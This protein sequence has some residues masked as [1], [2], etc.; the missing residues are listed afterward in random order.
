MS[1]PAGRRLAIASLPCRLFVGRLEQSSDPLESATNPGA[2]DSSPHDRS[3]L[4]RGA[5]EM[6]KSQVHKGLRLTVGLV[7]AVII[8]ASAA[9]VSIS[10]QAAATGKANA[11]TSAAASARAKFRT[12]WGHPDLQGVWSNATT[13]PLER[14]TNI[15]EKDALS[16]E[17]TSDVD[18]KTAVNLNTDR[19]DGAGTDVDVSRAY[20]EFWWER[21]KS[22][23]R[24]SLIVDPVDGRIP[25]LTPEGQKRADALAEARRARGPADS[26]E[27]RNLHERCIVYHSVPPLPTGYNNNYQILQTP[28]YVAILS[29]MIHEVRLIPLD[30]RPHMPQ[31]VRQWFGDSRGHWEGDTLVVETTNFTDLNDLNQRIRRGSGLTLNVTERFTRVDA[32]KIDYRFTV[33]DPATFTTPWTAELPMVK[34][35]APIYEYACHEGNYGMEGILSGHRAQER[36]A[37]AGEKK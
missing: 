31:T 12:P 27:D 33:N 19:R 20:N 10:G 34:L 36:A 15:A 2:C 6:E 4:R 22:I 5:G 17:E 7:A 32:G 23:G 14:P 8:A 1:T 3:A 11:K 29:E 18:Q 24:T 25:P 16:D 28:E 37:A 9:P 35:E 26:W 13:T 30:G 21:G